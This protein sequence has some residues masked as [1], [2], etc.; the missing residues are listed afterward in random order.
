[1]ADDCKNIFFLGKGGTGKT[2]I[3]A[4]TAIALCERGKKVALF[5]M[6]PAHNL[7]DVFDIPANKPVKSPYDTLVIE[8]ISISYWIE[9][10]LKSIEDKILKSYKYLTAINLEKHLKHR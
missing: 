9:T 3:S 10:Y 8:E 6:D 1:M 7:S 4:L 5:S 2:T